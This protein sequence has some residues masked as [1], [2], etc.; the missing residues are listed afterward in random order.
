MMNFECECGNTTRFFATGD[1][2]EQRRE[3]IEVEDEERLAVIFG[4]DSVLF[5][6]KFCNYTYR[7]QK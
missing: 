1:Q 4:E 7:L 5:Q 3:Y 2:D 6:C